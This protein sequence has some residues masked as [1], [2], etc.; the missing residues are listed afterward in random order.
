M[1]SSDS[2]SN[3]SVNN[4]CLKFIYIK[5]SLLYHENPTY[6]NPT[7]YFSIYNWTRTTPR[8]PSQLEL[9]S[10]YILHSVKSRSNCRSLSSRSVLVFQ[11][12]LYNI[13]PTF[14]MVSCNQRGAPC[15]RLCIIHPS[16]HN[17]RR[18]AEEFRRIC[19]SA[20]RRTSDPHGSGKYLVAMHGV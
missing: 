3:V 14:A 19:R 17:D 2:K 12:K 5:G 10:F 7:L 8:M 16:L 11:I 18:S 9:L 15:G 4:T 6:L 20:V 1:L 13:W